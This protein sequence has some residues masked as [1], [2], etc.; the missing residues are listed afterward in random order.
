MITSG[1]NSEQLQMKVAMLESQNTV[2]RRDVNAA[3]SAFSVFPR[4]KDSISDQEIIDRFQALIGDQSVP[5]QQLS[6]EHLYKIGAYRNSN[7]LINAS[8]QSVDTY[9]DALTW[10]GNGVTKDTPDESLLAV[11]G[12]KVSLSVVLSVLVCFAPAN[13]VR[14]FPG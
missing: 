11:L 8:R 10:L 1:R 14:S 6:R 3:F 2:S 9:E 7:T 12:V 5:A 13:D 4:D